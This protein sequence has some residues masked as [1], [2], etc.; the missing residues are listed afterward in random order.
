VIVDVLNGPVDPYPKVVPK[1][2]K[3]PDVGSKVTT[4]SNRI[5][6]EQVDAASF[7]LGEEVRVFRCWTAVLM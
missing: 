3:N 1:H 7:D 5:L 2:K 4:Y 6:V